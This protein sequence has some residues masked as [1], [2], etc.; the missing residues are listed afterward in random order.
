MTKFFKLYDRTSVDC[1]VDRH[2]LGL[3]GRPMLHEEQK[4]S[5]VGRPPGRL[6]FSVSL[7]NARGLC[8][9][10]RAV[11]HKLGSV[12]RAIDRQSGQNYVWI[13]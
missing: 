3:N 1:P 12:D 7:G 4:A 8:V 13:W 9:V 5:W 10:D 2:A 11:D 6:T